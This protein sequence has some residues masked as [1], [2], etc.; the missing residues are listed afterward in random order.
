MTTNDSRYP[1]L[2][3][4]LAEQAR[5]FSYFDGGI[6]EDLD[7]ATRRAVDLIE[8]HVEDAD[9]EDMMAV[10]VL[11]NCPPYIMLKS[12]RF[13]QDYSAGVQAMLDVHTSRNGITAENEDLIQVYSAVFI[14]HGENL[15]RR[16]RELS[17]ADVHWLADVREGL[18]EY[19]DD[20]ILIEGKIAPGL[21]VAEDA[22]IKD[23]FA[24]ID[25]KAPKALPGFI[26]KPR[27]PSPP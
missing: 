6:P 27:G 26:R 5:I 11:M 9:K 3:K 1:L 19:I 7:R 23:T 16:I 8:T 10:A 2:V 12:K 21:R 4:A 18:E 22:L 13:T 20:R 15:L 14:A 17:S 24:A 25:G